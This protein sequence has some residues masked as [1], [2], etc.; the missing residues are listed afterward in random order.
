MRIANRSATAPASPIRRLIP[1]ADRA[2]ERG[3]KVYHLNIG[4]PDIETPPEAMDAVRNADLRVLAYAPSQG[5]LE[6]RKAL[7]SYYAGAGV[8]LDPDEILVTVAG[9]EAITLAMATTLDVGDEILIPEPLYAN[10]LGFASL[11]GVKVV[12]I[13]CR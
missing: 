8:T 3:L 10:Y 13:S 7:V 11:L 4:Q 12:P 5:Y 6:Y 2:R 1:Y 9:S